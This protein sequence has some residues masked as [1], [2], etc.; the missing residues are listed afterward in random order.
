M[1]LYRYTLIEADAASNDYQESVQYAFATSPDAFD[2]LE[3]GEG[4]WDGWYCHVSD[5]TEV[6]EIPQ[7]WIDEQ[8]QS[9]YFRVPT[10]DTALE[11]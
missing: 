5:V 3:C 2:R 10:P 7:D 8:S 9:P 1:H 6:S 4:G 11:P